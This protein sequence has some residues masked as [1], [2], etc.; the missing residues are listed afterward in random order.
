MLSGIRQFHAVRQVLGFTQNSAPAL[1]GFDPEFYL[2]YYPDLVVLKTPARLRKHYLEYGRKEGRA[3]NFA[4]AQHNLEARE[5]KLPSDFDPSIYR[6]LNPDLNRVFDHL[7][8]YTLHFLEHG[9]RE[10]RPFKFQD[11]PQGSPGSASHW[12]A[13][14][15]LP[16][17]VAAASAW[18]EEPPLTKEAGIEIFLTKGVKRLAPISF[19]HVFD[20]KFYRSNYDVNASLSDEDLYRH[21]LES[22]VPNGFFPNESSAVASL[23]VGGQFPEAFDWSG[24]VAAAHLGPE[25]PPINRFRALRHLFEIGFE[26]GLK[27][28][29]K[30][31][32]AARLYEAIGDYHLIRGRHR[33]ATD[34]Y[35]A[36]LHLDANLTGARHRRG[37]A[38][39][40]LNQREAAYS[41]FLSVTASPSASV[42]A[43]IHAARLAGEAQRFKEAFEILEKGRPIWV[44]NASFRA[45]IVSTIDAFF[46]A[47]STIANSIY[48]AGARQGADAYLKCALQE[49]HEYISKLEAVGAGPIGNRYGHIVLLANQ[50]LQQ[51]KHY[52][53]EQKVRQLKLA[54]IEAI[55][56]DQHDTT[57]FQ[58]YIVGARAV[59]FYRVAAF[60]NIIRAIIAA[61]AS[62]I[63]TYYD[64]DDLIFDSE[65]YPDTFESYE[66]QISKTE[67]VGLMY[68]V[69]LFFYAMSLCDYGIASTPALANRMEPVVGMH[70]CFVLRNGLDDRNAIA[71][72]LGDKPLRQK[73]G[74]TIFYGSGTKAHNADFNELA[75]PAIIE[76]MQKYEDVRLVIVGHLKLRP[77]FDLLI[78]RINFVNFINDVNEYWCLLSAADINLAVLASSVMSDCK[79]EIK[80]LEAAIVGVPSIVSNT[81]TYREL[82]EHGVDALVVETTEDWRRALTQ[83]IEGE[84]LRLRVGSAARSKALADYSLESAARTL[85]NIFGP[86][87]PSKAEVAAS[88][89]PRAISIGNTNAA[90]QA[91]RK[92]RVLLCHVFFS[93]QTFGGAT[94]VVE[95]N[96]NYFIEN[97]DDIDVRIFTTDEGVSSPGRLRLDRYCGIPVF[98]VSTSTGENIDWESFDPQIGELFENILDIMQPDII[99]FHCL[100][101][102]SGMIVEVA[103]RRKIPYFITAH[104]GW[105]VSDHQF[106]VDSQGTLS[107][108]SRNLFDG[109]H[110]EGKN[111][112]ASLVRRRRLLHLLNSAHNV[113]AVSESFAEIYRNA[114]CETAIAIPNG[115]SRI[116]PPRSRVAHTDGR[117]SLGHIGDRSVHKG[118]TLVEGV[119]RSTQFDNLRLT[120]I[121]NRLEPGTRVETMWGNTPVTLSGPYPQDKVSELYAALDVLLAP[122]IWPESFG[123]VAREALA[124]GLW[125]IASDRGAMSECIKEGENGFRIDVSDGRQLREVLERIDVEPARYQAPPRNR[126]TE[127]RTAVDQGRELADLYRAVAVADF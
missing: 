104:D 56:C 123:L 121:D 99:H 92:I 53:V 116:E 3:K 30:G 33:L 91:K 83:L 16:E 109:A 28:Q 11:Y 69:P 103:R 35:S 8:Q 126:Q 7:W 97:C 106:L 49:V 107:L 90:R 84:Q 75:G 6:M 80:W 111:A 124:Q 112:V 89:S 10:G 120:M 47:K 81:R 32:G 22:G 74:V 108:P 114:G 58:E 78:D 29:I 24:Y 73:K 94:R 14:F 19:T 117:I 72:D 43:Y 50:D 65:F 77:E 85:E 98:R 76:A 54:G 42:W 15:K 125:V 39:L 52:R 59:I 23:I 62:E 71:A 122:S 86:G 5:G 66:S 127:L 87:K 48:E 38:F 55:V 45:T 82:L 46:A 68:G 4:E 61:K 31:P 70:R 1:D 118:A 101:R 105:W 34:A 95:D 21:W 37:D 17:F 79:S 9:R 119:L 26:R 60:P 100:Q 41:D 12:M 25:A 93:P 20:A 102:L 110:S 64:I 51:C 113:L 88:K 13:L 63:P 36:A 44:K 40:A 27:A 57:R 96:V 115:V 18:L 2:A 67:Y